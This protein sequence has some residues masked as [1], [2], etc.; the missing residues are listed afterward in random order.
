[1]SSSALPAS[2]T[3]LS[4]PAISHA[5][6]KA[7]VQQARQQRRR[8]LADSGDAAAGT[9]LTDV[10]NKPQ[11]TRGCSTAGG[12]LWGDTAGSIRESSSAGAAGGLSLGNVAACMTSGQ[13]DFQM[14]AAPGD[15]A[16]AAAAAQQQHVLTQWD[17][18]ARKGLEAAAQQV[19]SVDWGCCA[20]CNMQCSL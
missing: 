3:T 4:R 10:Y 9:Q 17:E 12:L 2:P 7:I 14:P 18:L 8:Q 13:R 11:I 16:A 19:V 6:S 5:V 15:V 1:M 20:A